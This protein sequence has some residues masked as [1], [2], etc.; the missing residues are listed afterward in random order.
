M[1]TLNKCSSSGKNIAH[2]QC[3]SSCQAPVLFNVTFTGRKG[4]ENHA[5]YQYQSTQFT[6]QLGQHTWK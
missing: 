5:C 6:V 1:L 3:F 4:Y 2:R